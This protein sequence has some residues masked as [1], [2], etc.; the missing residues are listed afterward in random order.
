MSGFV[1]HFEILAL[2]AEWKESVGVSAEAGGTV[3]GWHSHGGTRSE[4]GQ[5]GSWRGE[6]G[7]GSGVEMEPAEPTA[8]LN[9]AVG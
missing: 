9:V 2:A 5:P 4:V 7:W 6:E 1:F 8:G 3:K